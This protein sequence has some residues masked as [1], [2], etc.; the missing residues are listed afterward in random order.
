MNSPFHHLTLLRLAKHLEGRHDQKEHAGDRAPDSAL[1]KPAQSA[2]NE[3]VKGMTQT[4]RQALLNRDPVEEGS[5]VFLL[6]APAATIRGLLD[7]GMIAVDSTREHTGS[8]VSS[9]PF[10]SG[11]GM[12]TK[13]FNQLE[14]RYRLTGDGQAAITAGRAARDDEASLAAK[15]ALDWLK[16]SAAILAGG[17]KPAKLSALLSDP[18]WFGSFFEGSG[19]VFTKAALN[20]IGDAALAEAKMRLREGEHPSVREHFRERAADAAN[21]KKQAKRDASKE[22]YHRE[23]YQSGKTD[24]L[25]W[26]AQTLR[27][28]REKR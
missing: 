22:R 11:T 13:H 9:N 26:R 23:R 24:Q 16:D 1:D 10:W 3:D 2:H 20:R 18:G 25:R 4:M 5:D 7:R 14:V 12:R 8:N 17:K 19:K 6:D 21:A 15:I 27:Q 28:N